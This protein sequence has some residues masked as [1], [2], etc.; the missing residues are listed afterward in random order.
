MPER[1]HLRIW[2]ADKPGAQFVHH[3]I[4]IYDTVLAL[5]YEKLDEVTKI[6]LENKRLDIFE[7]IYTYYQV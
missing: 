7:K 6:A 3:V 4:I 5:F 2:Q 1:P